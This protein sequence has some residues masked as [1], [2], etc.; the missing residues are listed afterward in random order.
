MGIITITEL[1]KMSGL[2]SK[3]KICMLS[4]LYLR[5]IHDTRGLMVSEINRNLLKESI[6]VSV[7]APNDCGYKTFEMIDGIKVYRFNYFWPKRLQKLA[8]DSG[9]PTNLAVSF[10]AKLQVPPFTISFL[11]KTLKIAKGC[12]I[13][14]AQWIFSAFIGLLA[15]KIIRKPVVV[16]VRRVNNN[17]LMRFVNKYVLKNADFVIFNSSYT[18]KESLKIKRPK[19]Y[20]VIHNSIDTNK[21]RL[22]KTDLKTKLGLKDKVILF[23]MGLFVEKKGFLYLIKAM[24][25]IIKRH[26]NIILLLGG[27]GKEEKHLK[28]LVKKLNLN[29][30]IR[31]LGKI[32]ADKTP[33]FY[34][35]CDVFILPSIVDT[36]GETETLGVVLLEAMACGKPIVTTN[37]GGIPDVITRECGFLVEQKN[38]KKLAEKI[39]YLLSNKKVRDKMGI[40]GRKRI[41]ANFKWSREGKK[42]IDIYQNIRKRRLQ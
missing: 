13:I 22:L 2:T 6:N 8:Y 33:Y 27:Q 32:S 31:F 26:K 38:P 17:G 25:E 24:S 29:N 5:Y 7:V 20:E 12:D 41:E 4:T 19:M 28:D 21:F 36:K 10:L 3:L 35:I 34:N 37:I 1:L 40:N 39:D 18:M 23:S 14:H 15:K 9:I 30:Y 11:F 42:I 16:S